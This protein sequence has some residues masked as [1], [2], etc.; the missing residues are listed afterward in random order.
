[1][2]PRYGVKGKI[3]FVPYLS[4]YKSPDPYPLGQIDREIKG[5][6]PKWS[7]SNWQDEDVLAEYIWTERMGRQW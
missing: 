2:R 5:L 4:T 1:M 7:W 3:S 6:N